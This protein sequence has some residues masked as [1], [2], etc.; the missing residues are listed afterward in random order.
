MVL[1]MSACG[2]PG[3]SGPAQ[4]AIPLSS[5]A[6]PPSSS[7]TSLPTSCTLPPV[8]DL[9]IVTTAP[10]VPASAQVVGGL[11]LA[12]CR[13]TVDTLSATSPLDAG[14]CTQAANAADNPGY[15]AGAI[16]AAPLR[17]VLTQVGAGC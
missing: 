6:S 1:L 11:D 16:P 9:I 4:D 5:A 17:N 10:G 7:A 15:D 13:E 2:S 8:G 14:Y 12:Q 3:A